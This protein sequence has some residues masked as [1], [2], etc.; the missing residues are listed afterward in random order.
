MK[1]GWR[2]FLFMQYKDQLKHP[3]WQKKRLSVLKRD[4]FTCKKCGDKE[5][6][7]HVH[8][9]KYESGKLAWEIDNKFLITLCE[10]CHYEIED[11][12]GEIDF[13]KIFIHKMDKWQNGSRIMFM[14]LNDVLSMTVYN[15][16]NQRT[17]G[18]NI[19]KAHFP[20]LQNLFNKIKNG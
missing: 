15:N 10:H 7:L 3:E 19:P 6:T 20:K 9:L 14:S 2:A 8:H 11:I 4:K 16:T 18:F 12:E 1:H 5:T 13:E 17:S